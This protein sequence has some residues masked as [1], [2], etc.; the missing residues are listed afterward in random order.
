MEP[1]TQKSNTAVVSIISIIIAIGLLFGAIK[2]FGK[3]NNDQNQNSLATDNSSNAAENPIDTNPSVATAEPAITNKYK[4]GTYLAEGDYISPGGAES[5]QVTLTLKD[6]V[7]TDAK[8]VSNAFR[9]NT[10]EFQNMF[11]ANY[12]PLVIGKDISTLNLTKVSGSSLTPKGFDDAL[13]K[14]KSQSRV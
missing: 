13:E 2:Y 9:P 8:V 4:D 3:I 11:I 14:I 6:D 7:I 1:Q 5:I 12:K 10:I